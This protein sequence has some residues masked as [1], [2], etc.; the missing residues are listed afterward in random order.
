MRRTSRA[1]SS[2]LAAGEQP[3]SEREARQRDEPDVQA[4]HGQDVHDAGAGERVAQPRLVDTALVAQHQRLENGRARSGTARAIARRQPL[5]P[6]LESRR[7]AAGRRA[8]GAR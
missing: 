1:S 6:A 4:G 5:A 8:G 7:D 2:A 3:A